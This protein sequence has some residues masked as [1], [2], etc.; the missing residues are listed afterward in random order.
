MRLSAA[1]RRF[2]FALLGNVLALA[3]CSLVLVYSASHH[4][5]ALAHLVWKQMLW[6]GVGFLA[7]SV[8]YVVDYQSLIHSAYLYLGVIVFLLALLLFL[9]KTRGGSARWFHLGPV[10]IQPSELA[11]LALIL[12]VTRYV[13]ENKRE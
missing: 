13:S 5:A 7:M 8:F 4:S 6:L 12:A 11:K 2:D 9:G 3:F 1:W 10:N